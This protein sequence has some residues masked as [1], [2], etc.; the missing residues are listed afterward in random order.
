MSIFKPLDHLTLIDFEP[1]IW[2][3]EVVMRSAFISLCLAGFSAMAAWAQSGPA[4]GVLLLH[5]NSKPWPVSE[6]GLVNISIFIKEGFKI[7]KRPSPKLQISSTPEFEIKGEIRFAEE[8][9]GKDPEYFN[10]FKPMAL[11]VVA[12]K[13]T[14]PGR[15]SLPGKFVYFYCSDKER[16]CSRSVETVHIPIEI[17]AK[18]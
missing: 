18:K 5:S 13:S 14:L 3:D 17:I 7:P 4:A 12:A 10:A 11:E 6:T 8:G 1:K 15:Y 9:Q 16:Y 2:S